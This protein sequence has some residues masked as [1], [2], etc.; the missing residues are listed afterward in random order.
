MLVAKATQNFFAFFHF[1]QHFYSA[2][3][4]NR[5]SSGIDLGS[6]EPPDNPSTAGTSSD[7]YGLTYL[8]SM[9]RGHEKPRAAFMEKS[10]TQDDRK[11]VPF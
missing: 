1:L 2:Q 7:N 8:T 5:T 9:Y 10:G 3:S 11:N 6:L 4:G